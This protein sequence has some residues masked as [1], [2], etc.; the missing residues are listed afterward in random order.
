MIITGSYI[1]GRVERERNPTRAVNVGFRSRSTRPTPLSFFINICDKL[2]K[3]NRKL[4]NLERS[5]EF[6]VF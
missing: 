4:N 3:K 2:D 1:V 6:V 5:N